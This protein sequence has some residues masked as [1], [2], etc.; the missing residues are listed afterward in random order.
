MK[1]RKFVQAGVGIV[2][3]ALASELVEA[4]TPANAA[5]T[6]RQEKDPATVFIDIEMDQP[7]EDLRPI[8]RFFAS[9]WT[10]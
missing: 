4:I 7:K 8:W 10:K 3:G 9:I 6:A 1:R 5:E 2:A